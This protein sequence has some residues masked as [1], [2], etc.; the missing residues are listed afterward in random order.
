MQTVATAGA[1][2]AA[3]GQVSVV[4]LLDHVS[5]ELG[6]GPMCGVPPGPKV[7]LPPRLR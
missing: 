4:L 1:E 6:C 5:P 7:F 2:I 3:S